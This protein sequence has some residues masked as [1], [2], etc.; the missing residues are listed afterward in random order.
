MCVNDCLFV[1]VRVREREK[2]RQRELVVYCWLVL[3]RH[4]C[5]NLAILVR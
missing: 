3:T 5:V 2:E 4:T 1:C